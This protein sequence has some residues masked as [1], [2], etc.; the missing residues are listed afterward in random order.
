MKTVGCA[1]SR[2][3]EIGVPFRFS[4]L[5]MTDGKKNDENIDV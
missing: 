4:R 1:Q 5:Q 3:T 2:K